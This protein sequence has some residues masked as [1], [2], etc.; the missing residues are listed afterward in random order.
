MIIYFLNHGDSSAQNSLSALFLCHLT[1]PSIAE[2]GDQQHSCSPPGCYHPSVLV[3]RLDLRFSINYPRLSCCHFLISR[4]VLS[5]GKGL[6]CN[7]FHF[8]DGVK[9]CEMEGEK[10]RFQ[11]CLQAQVQEKQADLWA[12]VLRKPSFL[13]LL[14]VGFLKATNH[15]WDSHHDVLP[16]GT[17]LCP[18]PPLCYFFSWNLNRNL[19]DFHPAGMEA[20]IRVKTCSEWGTQ[21]DRMMQ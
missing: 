6:V 14:P 1:W 4:S 5:E 13:Q 20:G 11:L 15:S 9:T 19:W 2:R 17:N 16:E 7:K 21:Q 8:Q 18:S 12:V 3:F 10:D